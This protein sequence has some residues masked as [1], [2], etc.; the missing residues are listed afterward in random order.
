MTYQETK[1]II[2]KKVVTFKKEAKLRDIAKKMAE[3]NISCVIIEENK[4]PIGVLTERDIIKKVISQKKD[5]EKVLAIDIMSYPVVTVN[6]EVGI[7]A[8][9]Q[10]MKKKQIRRVVVTKNERIYGL[11]TQ[12]DIMEGMINKVKHLNWQLVHTEISLD[13]YIDSLKNIQLETVTGK[14]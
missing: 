10:L 1:N 3:I 6:E 5:S 13:E 7:I 14:K 11:I 2:S 12:T 4:K 8:I 9:A